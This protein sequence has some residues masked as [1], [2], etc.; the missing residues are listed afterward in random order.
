VIPQFELDA[1]FKNFKSTLLDIDCESRPQTIKVDD[2]LIKTESSGKTRIIIEKY[3][4]NG[5]QLCL[6][7]ATFMPI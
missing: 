5:N 7:I 1:T 2:D 6:P 4:R 3:E